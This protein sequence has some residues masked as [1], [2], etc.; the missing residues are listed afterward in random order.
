MKYFGLEFYK[1]KRK[2]IILMI[3]LFVVVEIMWCIVN[4]NRVIICN[5]DMLGGFEYFY[6]FMSFVS[7][8]GLFFFILILIIILC[9]SDIEYKGD[10]WKF[11]KFFV[12]FLNSIYLF[13]FLCFVILVFIFVLM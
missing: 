5:L 1:F 10:I 13:K 4:L 8:N 6:M 9:I 2:K 7:L 3:F 11:L 12:I